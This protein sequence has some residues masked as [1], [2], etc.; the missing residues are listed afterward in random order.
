VDSVTKAVVTY[1]PHEPISRSVDN[2]AMNYTLF[3]NDDEPVDSIYITRDY[4]NVWLTIPVVMVKTVPL[5]VDLILG[6]GLTR[7]NVSIDIEP[8]SVRIAGDPAQLEIVNV[9]QIVQINLSTQEDDIDSVYVIHY[10]AGIRNIEHIYE[11]HLTFNIHAATRVI[12]TTNIT[13]HGLN[14]SEG[15]TH[16]IVTSPVAVTLRGPAAADVNRVEPNHVRVVA[17]FSDIEITLAGRH[18][19]TALV[20]VD[21]HDTVGVIEKGYEVTIEIVSIVPTEED[22][23]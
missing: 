1:E 10:P 21:G 12:H 19:A 2:I 8:K 18:R 7:D 6:G 4:P 13:V 22:M 14:L 20:Y 9:I 16:N 23:A 15:Y 11:A 17:D 5:D 3:T